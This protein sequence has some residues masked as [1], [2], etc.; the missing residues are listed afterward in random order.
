MKTK[1]LVVIFMLIISFFAKAEKTY[2]RDHDVCR[3]KGELID[4][5]LKTSEQYSV[6]EDDEYGEIVFLKHKDKLTRVDLRDMGMGRYRMLKLYNDYCPKLLAIPTKD[7]EI[8]FFFMKDNRPFTDLLMVFFYNTKT[9]ESELVSTY[10]PVKGALSKDKK[11]YFKT[12][13]NVEVKYGTTTING[14]K[15]NYMERPLEPWVSFDGKNFKLDLD[16][17]REKFEYKDLLKKAHWS[18]VTDYKNATISIAVNPTLKKQ[19]ISLNQSE[20]VCN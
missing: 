14:Q 8:A 15:Y 10:M 11:I 5:D 4:I 18:T 13:K 17:S 1:L 6:S 20:W 9:N 7:D 2:R 12:S 16:L 3:Y 19:C